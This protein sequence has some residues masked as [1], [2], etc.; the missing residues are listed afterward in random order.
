MRPPWLY[1]LLLNPLRRWSERDDRLLVEH[2]KAAYG[3]A[4][5][6]KVVPFRNLLIVRAE[7]SGAPRRRSA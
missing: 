5:Q 3:P 6:P 7:A 2:W 1:R 4:P